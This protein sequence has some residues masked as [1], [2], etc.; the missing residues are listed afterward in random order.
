MPRTKYGLLTYAGFTYTLTGLFILFYDMTPL[1]R[2]CAIIDTIILHIHTNDAYT[3]D[4][5][6][7]ARGCAERAGFVAARGDQGALQGT[8]YVIVF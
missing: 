7:D 8:I 5:G 1:R 4:T 2:G 6:E 3:Y